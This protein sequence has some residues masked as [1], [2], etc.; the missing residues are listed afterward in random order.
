MRLVQEAL[1]APR[2]PA[3]REGPSWRNILSATRQRGSTKKKGPKPQRTGCGSPQTAGTG[4][5]GCLAACCP[6][7]C[8]RRCEGEK[9]K[10]LILIFWIRVARTADPRLH[11]GRCPQCSAHR[12]ASMASEL[13]KGEILILILIFKTLS[14]THPSRRQPCAA[15]GPMCRCCRAATTAAETE[16]T[17]RKR[18]A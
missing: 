7:G 15:A 9:T 4:T 10:F 12:C 18:I 3:K 2:Q 5:A 13:R 14:E 8:C 17:R 16:E 6:G 11:P 1:G